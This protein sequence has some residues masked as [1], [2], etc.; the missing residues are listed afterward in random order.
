[1]FTFS[2]FNETTLFW[3][4]T[5]YEPRK[6]H[7]T[8]VGQFLNNTFLM[9]LNLGFVGWF[10]SGLSRVRGSVIYII[11]LSISLAMTMFSSSHALTLTMRAD[12]NGLEQKLT[13]MIKLKY[14]DDTSTN[15]VF[16]TFLVYVLFRI[17]WERF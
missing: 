5:F 3:S 9:I 10:A 13:D 15:Q 16:K 1:M 4:K 2:E 12:F 11:I 14:G 8:F 17:L 7:K 6:P